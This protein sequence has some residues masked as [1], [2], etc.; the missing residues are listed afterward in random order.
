MV[1]LEFTMIFNP[2]ELSDVSLI[3][4][5]RRSDERGS[6]ARVFCEREFAAAGLCTRFVQQNASVSTTKGTLRGMHYQL[7]A[8]SEVKLIRCLRGAIFDV[9]IDLRE[10]SPTFMKWQGFELSDANGRLL[11]APRGF[12]HGF[13]TLTD[14][15]EVSYLVSAFY[16]PQAEGGVRWDEPAF[17]IDWPFAPVVVS[18][19]DQAWPDM[20]IENPPFRYGAV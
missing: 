3:E 13:L 17:A 18:A 14:N 8:D 15:V 1:N 10:G 19:R 20:Q 16:A 5:E 7:G 9:L 6:F 12:A 2:A 4:Q 11:Y